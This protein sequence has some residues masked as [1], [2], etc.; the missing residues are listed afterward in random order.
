MIAPHV[1]RSGFLFSGSVADNIR[2]G[3]PEATR[4][5]IE[6]AA[7]AVGAE[8]VIGALLHGLDT[9]VGE[10]GVLLSAGERRHG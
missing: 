6:A 5:E 1:P 7:S 9:E 8:P 4:A 2:F 3:R 10:R